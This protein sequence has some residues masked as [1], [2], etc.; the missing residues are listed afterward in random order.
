MDS[1]S[2][3]LSDNSYLDKDIGQRHWEGFPLAG[4]PPLPQLGNEK[5]PASAPR[6]TE[7]PVPKPWGSHPLFIN[8]AHR[9]REEK[10]SA[11]LGRRSRFRGTEGDNCLYSQGTLGKGWGSSD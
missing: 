6:D 2:F 8:A 10:L 11:L 9:Q 7:L 5:S 3:S 1:V 4:G